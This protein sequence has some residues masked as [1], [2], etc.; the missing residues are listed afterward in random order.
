MTAICA[1]RPKA[2]VDVEWPLQTAAV[3]P[4]LGGV[5][6][7]MSR[8]GRPEVRGEAAIGGTEGVRQ[9]RSFPKDAANVS[10]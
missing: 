4:Q 6:V 2:G 8:Q 5:P 9:D 10:I 7:Y 1:F 3:E